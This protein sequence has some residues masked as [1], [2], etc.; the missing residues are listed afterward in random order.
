MLVVTAATAVTA[1]A[2][3]QQ[4]SVT[5]NNVQYTVTEMPAGRS[6]AHMVQLAGPEGAAMV[7]VDRDN[8][9]TAYLSPPGGGQYKAQIDALWAAYL[10]QKK[11]SASATSTPSSE[12]DPN[13]ALRAQ[14]A[15]L[16][17]GRSASSTA[18]QE[19][20]VKGPAPGGGLIV[21]DPNLGGSGGADVTISPDGMKAEWVVIP[22]RNYPPTKYTAEF[23]GG[24]K[25]ASGGSRALKGTKGMLGAT[26]TSYNPRADATV[27]MSSNP[28][29]DWRVISQGSDG[30]RTTELGGWR[31]GEYVADTGRD[32]LKSV[33]LQQLESVKQD[34]LA[35]QAYKDK[36]GN[37]PVVLTSDRSQRGMTA[38]DKITKVYNDPKP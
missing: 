19:P 8:K 10:A 11:G 3:V 31:Q 25:P 4:T 37:Q 20:V 23:E 30:K 35:A 16:A 18:G 32:P 24:D 5:I 13:A 6:P 21:H 36:D 27:N 15:A 2:Q 34:V 38:L 14:A 9:I 29:N 33:A 26:V 22:G 1:I 7:Q 28:D 17:A 12:P